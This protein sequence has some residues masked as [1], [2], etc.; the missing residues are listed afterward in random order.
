MPQR[1]MEVEGEVVAYLIDQERDRALIELPGEPVVGGLRTWIPT[2]ELGE[3][4]EARPE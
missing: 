1:G 4:V 3:V 2:A